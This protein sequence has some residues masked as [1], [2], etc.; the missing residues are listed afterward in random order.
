MGRKKNEAGKKASDGHTTF[1]AFF[2]R[3]QIRSAAEEGKKA[4]NAQLK[5]RE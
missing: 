4:C 2:A 5:K 3:Q 1:F